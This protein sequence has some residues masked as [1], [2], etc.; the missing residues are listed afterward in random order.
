MFQVILNVM[1]NLTG[2]AFAIAAIVLYSINSRNIWF[3]RVCSDMHLRRSSPLLE[4]CSR[5]EAIILVSV[6]NAVS[7]V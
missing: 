7:T 3:G 4:E 1:A 6:K 2:V 5:A